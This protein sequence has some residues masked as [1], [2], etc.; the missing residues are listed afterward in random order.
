MVQLALLGICR[1]GEGEG[2]VFACAG[3]VKA[4]Y[5]PRQ[6]RAGQKLVLRMVLGISR[7]DWSTNRAFRL[8][9]AHVPLNRFTYPPAELLTKATFPLTTATATGEK[10]RLRPCAMT[11]GIA[12]WTS[13]AADPDSL[14]QILFQNFSEETP[15]PP[16][17]PQT[18]TSQPESS[19]LFSGWFRNAAA[20]SE[21]R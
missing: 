15:L 11:M 16:A 7:E 6:P 17:D 4:T 12:I 10:A 2:I 13:A 14:R 19:F 18:E 20:E 8:A 1:G 21:E 5:R 3:Y 9:L